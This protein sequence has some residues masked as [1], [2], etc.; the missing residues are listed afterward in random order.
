MSIPLNLAVCTPKICTEKHFENPETFQYL[1]GT[2]THPILGELATARCLQ[3]L[4]WM[5]FKNTDDFLEVIGEASLELQ[6]FSLGFF[7]K[8]NDIHP[9]VVNGGAKSG[10]ECW[11][12][13]LSVGDTLYVEVVNVGEEVYYAR[14]LYT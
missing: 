10:S 5:R 9:W 6:E 4:G 1:N 12:T 13:R 14:F 8:Y 3:I 11:G 7:D 2:L